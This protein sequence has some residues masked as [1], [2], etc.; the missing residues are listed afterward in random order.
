MNEWVYW[1]LAGMV[2]VLHL[3]FV[4]FAAAGGL[5]VLRLPVL[6]WV[7]VPTA[8]WAAFVELSGRLCPLTPLENALRRRAGMDAYSGDFVA[9]YLLPVLYPEGLTRDVQIAIG[10]FVIAVNVATYG[11]LVRRRLI[12]GRAAPTRPGGDPKL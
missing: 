12:A 7:H 3:A 11:W 10:A 2:V 5:L 8:F 9:Q 6:A 4:V 1:F